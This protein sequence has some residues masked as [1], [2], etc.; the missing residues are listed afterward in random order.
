MTSVAN[1]LV[2]LPAIDASDPWSIFPVAK[3]FIDARWERRE[4]LIKQS[5]EIT[6]DSKKLIVALH[7]L[8]MFDTAG[9]AAATDKPLARIAQLCAT[10]NTTIGHPVNKERFYRDLR[11]GMEELIEALSFRHYLQ[12]GKLL[13]YEETV[14]AL[15][16]S[17][18]SV[19]PELYILGLMDLGGELMRYATSQA[20]N[21]AVGI[22]FAVCHFMQQ[23]FHG[24]PF[25]F[26]VCMYVRE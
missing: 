10:V 20:T 3:H 6:R 25:P 7:R 9:L 21:R 16:A 18:H 15:A 11:P 2:V 4:V 17:G 5:R 8:Q 24:I 26:F 22:V 19:T 23:F 1:A 12:T 14:S 13:S